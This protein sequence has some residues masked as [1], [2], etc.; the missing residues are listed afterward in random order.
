[1]DLSHDGRKLQLV[2]QSTNI[3]HI[4]STCVSTLNHFSRVRLFVIPWTIVHQAPL[5]MGFSREEYWSRLPFPS[6]GVFLTQGSNLS[7]LH[8]QV[9]SLHTEPPRKPQWRHC[10]MPKVQG[11]LLGIKLGTHSG[12]NWNQPVTPKLSR[13]LTW[14]HCR[15]KNRVNLFFP[16]FLLFW[17]ASYIV[18]WVFFPI[19][20]KKIERIPKS[21]S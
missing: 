9:D 16:S 8:W 10:Q 1:M 21:Y 2:I 17:K 11:T 5:F 14:P 12:R 20:K 3:L 19:S 6:P 18:I 13:Q 7:L 4:A 15:G